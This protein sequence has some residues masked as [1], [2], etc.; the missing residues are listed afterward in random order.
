MESAAGV[1]VIWHGIPFETLVIPAKLVL[2]ESGGA[3][4][5]SVESAF[6]KV[7]GVDSRSPAFAEDKLR[8][9]DCHLQGPCLAKDVGTSLLRSRLRV[10]P[11]SEKDSLSV[12]Q[13]NPKYL[14]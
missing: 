11:R 13:S 5:Q 3:G 6:P 1:G 12:T 8:G 4:I 14:N 7:R 9:N 2:R 10:G